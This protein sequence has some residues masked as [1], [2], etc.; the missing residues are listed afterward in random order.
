MNL[1]A[2]SVDIA[3]NLV[4]YSVDLADSFAADSVT[5]L[6]DNYMLDYSDYLAHS[7]RLVHSVHCCTADFAASFE[8]YMLDWDYLVHSVHMVL[9]HLGLV[10]CCT[11]NS[12]AGLT[13][14]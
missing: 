10:H 9:V 8:K 5:S 4:A 14:D 13:A 2:G 6:E 7:V 3:A 11:G 1:T 12:A